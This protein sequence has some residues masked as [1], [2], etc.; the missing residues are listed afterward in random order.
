MAGID[1]RIGGNMNRVLV[2]CLVANMACAVVCGAL[3]LFYP[4]NSGFTITTATSTHYFPGGVLLS[5]A[6]LCF[7]DLTIGVYLAWWLLNLR[8]R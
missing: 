6:L 3:L 5:A 1:K 4:K 7:L 8:T 2:G